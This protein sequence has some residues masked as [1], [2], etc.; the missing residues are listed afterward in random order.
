MPVCRGSGIATGRGAVP[1]VAAPYGASRDAHHGRTGLDVVDHHGVG[2][3]ARAV[4]DGDRADELGAGADV[5]V[6][7]QHGAG[8]GAAVADGHLVLQVDVGPSA[9]LAVDDDAVG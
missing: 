4:A 3:D 9:D 2:A 7:A 6:V 8:A 1:R 5:H